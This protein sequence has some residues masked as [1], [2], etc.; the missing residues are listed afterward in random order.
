MTPK[1]RRV[2][3]FVGS[4]IAKGALQAVGGIAIYLLVLYLIMSNFFSRKHAS[5]IDDALMMRSP[6]MKRVMDREGN[7]FEN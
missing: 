5:A 1:I 2:M 7:V 6:G 3:R 4:H